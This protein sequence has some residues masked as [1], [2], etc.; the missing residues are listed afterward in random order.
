MKVNN[1]NEGGQNPPARRQCFYKGPC[2]PNGSWFSETGEKWGLIRDFFVLMSQLAVTLMTVQDPLD[3][4]AGDVQAAGL[5]LTVYPSIKQHQWPVLDSSLRHTSSSFIRG[6]VFWFFISITKS[7]PPISLCNTTQYAKSRTRAEQLN[8][9]WMST[10]P[11]HSYTP[12][13]GWGWSLFAFWIAKTS[14]RGEWT[15]IL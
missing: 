8:W 6:S 11:P 4:T 10:C 5:G 12:W 14:G 3:P 9:M 1:V 2:Y 15:L 13:D 7:P